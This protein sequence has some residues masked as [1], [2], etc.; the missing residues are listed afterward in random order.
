MTSAS[1]QW[2]R[3]ARSTSR[4]SPSGIRRSVTIT[5][6]PSSVS[7]LMAAATPSIS[8]TWWPRFLRRRPRV[9]RAEGS[10]STMRMVAIVVLSPKGEEKGAA[11]PA[12]G[13]R[14][15][16]DP[17]AVS[18]HDAPSD[19]EAEAGACGFARVEGLEDSAALLGGHAAASVGDV[20]GNLS[21]AE[22]DRDAEA[23]RSAHGFDAVQGDVPHHLGDL[24]RVEG[25]RRHLGID[26]HRELHVLRPTGV[27]TDEGRHLIDDLA[28]VA[29]EP[30]ALA[31]AG[32]AQEVGEDAVEPPRLLL[33]HAQGVG[34][35]LSREGFFHAEERGGIDDG[36]QGIADLVGHAGR[37]LTG[38]GQPLR[39][40]EAGLEPLAFRHIGDQLEEEH[41]AVGLPY[42][43]AAQRVAPSVRT[44]H[45]ETLRRT[46]LTAT[47]ERTA[48]AG[49]GAGIDRLVAEAPGDRAELLVHPPV[50]V[51]DGEVAAHELEALPKAA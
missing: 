5:S 39:L 44:G 46:H 12:S 11:R 33:H 28:D 22:A 40:G 7:A 35:L 29:H 51:T 49:V 48:G 36:G 45:V 38:R 1:G 31:G 20:D 10:S 6:N 4:P 37:E 43:R 24:I 3:A 13:R 32:E 21:L 18:R 19:G 23:P 8:V 17:S 34:P 2:A 14:L 41:L 25:E 50:G 47:L 16:L 9:L 27:V 26:T 15:D 30:L 42:G